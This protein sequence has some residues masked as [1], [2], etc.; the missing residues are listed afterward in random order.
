MLKLRIKVY[1]IL[2]YVLQ[3][4]KDGTSWNDLYHCEQRYN[5]LVKI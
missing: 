3:R 5:Y 2:K 4:N 1:K